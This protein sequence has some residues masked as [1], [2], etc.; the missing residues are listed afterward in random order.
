[1]QVVYDALPEF[2]RKSIDAGKPYPVAANDP[3]VNAAPD[4]DDKIAF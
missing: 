4:F 1:V 3:A 2:L